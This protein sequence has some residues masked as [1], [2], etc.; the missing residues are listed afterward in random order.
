MISISIGLHLGVVVSIGKNKV[1]IIKHRDHSE[2]AEKHKHRSEYPKQKRK[3][4]VEEA[5]PDRVQD[6]ALLQELR[7]VVGRDG[8]R[9]VLGAVDQN[10]HLVH[11][12][13]G[14]GVAKEGEE[15][16]GEEGHIFER[17]HE[18]AV[19]AVNRVVHRLLDAV[20][21]AQNRSQPG[22][23]EDGGRRH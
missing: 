7:D 5:I 9:R 1:K 23:E 17:H 13:D 16:D 20:R 12:S 8:G 3:S 11:K 14:E 21:A 10:V 18:L 4:R 15:E 19:G 6:E 22:G 2:R